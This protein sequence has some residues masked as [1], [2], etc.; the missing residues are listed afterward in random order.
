MLI[1]SRSGNLFASPEPPL[2]FR[3][4]VHFVENK[5]QWENFI[6]YEANFR[7]GQI[8]L[9]NNRYTYVFYHP[10]D[11]QSLHPHVGIQIDK[12]RLQIGRAHV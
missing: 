1:F 4:K 6:R 11:I 7:G 2:K 12:I 8:F 3:S 9:E 5:N 10:D